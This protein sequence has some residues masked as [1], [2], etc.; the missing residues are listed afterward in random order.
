M[1]DRGNE[2]AAL[3]GSTASTGNTP[4]WHD[5]RITEINVIQARKPLPRRNLAHCRLRRSGGMLVDRAAEL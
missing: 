5:M 3:A 4:N 1:S 2:I